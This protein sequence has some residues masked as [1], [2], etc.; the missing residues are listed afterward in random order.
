MRIRLALATA[1]IAIVATAGSTFTLAAPSPRPSP[2][3]TPNPTLA[4]LSRLAGRDLDLAVMREFIP[5]F[6]EDIEIA[7]AAT[8]NADHPPL[9]QWNQRMIERKSAQVKRILAF[10]KDAGAAP[11]RR[12]ASVVTPHVT[13]MRQLRGGQLE[14]RYMTLMIERFEHNTAV[15]GAVVARGA[16][17]DLKTLARDVTRIERQE[18]AMLKKWY[19]EW[20][21]R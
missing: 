9:L 16:H 8:L 5:R 1:A 13:Q 20:Y 3:P 2:T 18:I 10:L 12:G 21:G 14:R 4:S 7:Y 15:A 17:V 6:E 19:Q 11:G